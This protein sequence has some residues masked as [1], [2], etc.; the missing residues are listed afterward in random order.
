M[1]RDLSAAVLTKVEPLSQDMGQSHPLRILVAED[2]KVNQKVAVGLLGKIGY[3][4]D[5]AVDG[6]EVLEALKRQPYDVILMDGQMPEMDGEQATL[7]IRKRWPTA[8]QPRIIAMTANVL[9]GERERYLAMG[10][11][12]YITKPI[13]IEDLVRVLNQSQPL[14]SP[15]DKTVD[16]NTSDIVFDPLVS[17]RRDVKQNDHDL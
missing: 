8:K 3:R 9:K 11:D 10:M 7:E 14:A 6:L 4:A 15:Q 12:D 13:R 1:N 17:Y 2:N 5:I 16:G